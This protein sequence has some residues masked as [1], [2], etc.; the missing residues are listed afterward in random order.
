MDDVIPFFH[1]A[2]NLIRYIIYLNDC[3]LEEAL[4]VT[5]HEIYHR[6]EH[7]IIDSL[8]VLEEAGIQY[9]ELEYYEEAKEI[10]S[11]SDNYYLD[12]LSYS[13][14]SQNLL[15]VKA[16]EHAKNEVKFLREAGYLK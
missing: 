3:S 6:Y 13:S 15:E 14:Y 4:R 1:T 10:K 9:E 8:E 2:F 16:E 12:S 11:A 7:A 5:S